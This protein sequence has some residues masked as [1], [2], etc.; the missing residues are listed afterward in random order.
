MSYEYFQERYIFRIHT[1]KYGGNFE[2][3][4]G[5]YITA[6]HDGTHGKDLAQ[7]VEEN[8]PELV[9][10]F[11]DVVIPYPDDNGYHRYATIVPSAYY[12]NDG[13]GNVWPVDEWL[14]EECVQTYRETVIE[15]NK[16]REE[17]GYPLYEIKKVPERNDAYY[18]VGLYLTK[19]VPA[20]TLQFMEDRAQEFIDRLKAGDLD[21][22]CRMAEFMPKDIVIHG[23]DVVRIKP[24][25]EVLWKSSTSKN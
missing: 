2:R 5:A 25:T 4:M 20:E 16:E 17:K 12:A 6:R 23:T 14:S 7:W 13:Y 10:R 8:E 19:A 11:D 3:Q 1:N 9:E 21:D 22:A 15:R 24:Q 18:S